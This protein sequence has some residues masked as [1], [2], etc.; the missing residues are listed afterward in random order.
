MKKSSKLK[1][2]SIGSLSQNYVRTLLLEKYSSIQAKNPKYSL[3]A[4]AAFLT[5]DQSLLTKFLKHNQNLSHESLVT[6]L[7]RIDRY[8]EFFLKIAGP[9]KALEKN[10]LEA[11]VI[12]ILSDWKYF[13][14]LEL[15]LIKTEQFTVERISLRLGINEK[16]VAHMVEI[17]EKL[18]LISIDGGV[19][20]YKNY[21]NSWFEEKKTSADRIKLQRDY[22]EKSRSALETVEYNLRH[23]SSMTIA[24]NKKH[25]PAIKVAIDKFTE[26]LAKVAQQDS[27]FDEVYQLQVSF[28]PLTE[29]TV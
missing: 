29:I 22:L 28:F 1:Q 12:K 18:S 27:D 21:F 20:T 4:F 5:I 8:D 26:D 19:I 13:A 16:G 25:L 2:P 9:G 10:I 24:I 3:R 15:L 23:H 11:D 6:C 17:L 14:I 7:Q